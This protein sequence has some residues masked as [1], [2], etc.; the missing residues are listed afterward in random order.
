MMASNP[1]RHPF[2][3]RRPPMTATPPSRRNF[4]KATAATAAAATLPAPA[5][6]AAGSDVLKVGLVGCG[7]RGKGAVGDALRA[8]PNV[9]V[10]ALC[11]IFPDFLANAYADLKKA[12]KDR[13]DV[14]EDRRY[15]G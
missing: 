2:P 8:G 9:K 13:L 1:P 4:L 3:P 12:W 5:V 14:P 7:G 6:R 10:T 11:D 15:T